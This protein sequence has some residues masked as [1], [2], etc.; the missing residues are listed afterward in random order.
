MGASCGAVKTQVR[1][2]LS[3][4]ELS[5]ADVAGTVTDHLKAN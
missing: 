5:S 2:H 1:E 3:L 4:K